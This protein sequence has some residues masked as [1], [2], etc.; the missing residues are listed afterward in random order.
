MGEAILPETPERAEFRKQAGLDGVDLGDDCAKLLIET[1]FQL[2][3]L[4]LERAPV[5]LLLEG[6]GEHRKRS[7][8]ANAHDW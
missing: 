4:G 3:E 8:I 2:A 1:F 7:S 5:P 6:A